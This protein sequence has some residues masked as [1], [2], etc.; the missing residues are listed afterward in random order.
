M[1][2]SSSIF[3]YFTSRYVMIVWVVDWYCTVCPFH[4]VPQHG[5]SHGS[6]TS[7]EAFIRRGYGIG[8]PPT[9]QLTWFNIRVWRRMSFYCVMNFPHSGTR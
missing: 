6:F 9:V 3:S 1:Y 5:G 4:R 8:C 7:Y 2:C